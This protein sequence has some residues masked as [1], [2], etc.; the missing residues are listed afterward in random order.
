METISLTLPAE[1]LGRLREQVARGVF[2]SETHAVHEAIRQME[3]R[4]YYDKLR[5]L[6]E[7]LSI[8][9]AQLE[10]GEGAEFTPD[11]IR[12]MNDELDRDQ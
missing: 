9:L 8:G 5:I 6:R 2:P 3:E 4:E 7:E 10:R 12:E 11:L 1:I